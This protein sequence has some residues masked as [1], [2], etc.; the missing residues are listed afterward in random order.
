MLPPNLCHN[1]NCLAQKALTQYG[2]NIEIL[3][4]SMLFLGLPMWLSAKEYACQCRIFEFDPWVGKAPCRRQWQPTPVFLPGESH[5]ERSLVGY[6]PGFAKSQIRQHIQYTYRAS[7]RSSSSGIQSPWSFT[8]FR[9]RREVRRDFRGA[10]RQAAF[11]PAA[12][13]RADTSVH[14]AER[15][16]VSLGHSFLISDQGQGITVKPAKGRVIVG[17]RDLGWLRSPSPFPA[18][19]SSSVVPTLPTFPLPLSP[20]HTQKRGDLGSAF[21][22]RPNSGRGSW[23][24]LASHWPTVQLWETLQVCGLCL[25]TDDLVV[26]GTVFL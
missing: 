19:K 8:S 18:Q 21:R 14:C 1:T 12:Q 4:V 10:G 15:S 3:Y 24:H 26:P 6:N 17:V 2:I 23:R 20:P 22:R 13:L 11:F 9:L 5:G 16:S 7:N 25:L